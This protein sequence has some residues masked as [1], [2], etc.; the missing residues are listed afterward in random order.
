MKVCDNIYCKYLL[1][2]DSACTLGEDKKSVYKGGEMSR[3]VNLS[4]FLLNANKNLNN[5]E[6]GASRLVDFLTSILPSS[7]V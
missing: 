4:R 6:W 5:Y 2:L 1:I 7:S 3:N